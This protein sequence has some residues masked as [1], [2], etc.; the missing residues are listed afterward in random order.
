MKTEQRKWNNNEIVTVPFTRTAIA[1]LI[2]GKHLV[3]YN[4]DL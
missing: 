2:I 3:V 1:L 4:L